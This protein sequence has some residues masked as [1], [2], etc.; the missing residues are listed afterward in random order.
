LK[1]QYH[2]IIAL[3]IFAIIPVLFYFLINTM[4]SIKNETDSI[5]T[6][7]SSV[8]GEN[9]CTKV[10]QIKIGIYIDLIV[11]IFWLGLRSFM[12]KK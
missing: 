8:T 12:V 2:T 9:L 3:I 1:K 10:S 11:L 7:I 5:E 4:V 6:C